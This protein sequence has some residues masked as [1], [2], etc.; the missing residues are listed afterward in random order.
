MKHSNQPAF[1]AYVPHSQ[2]CPHIIL[3][4]AGKLCGDRIPTWTTTGVVMSQ[5]HT[6][7]VMLHLASHF[8][9]VVCPFMSL[10]IHFLQLLSIS[11]I[12]VVY[13]IH[14]ESPIFK[15]ASNLQTL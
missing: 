3:E 13:K 11:E 1:R 10:S 6:Y 4:R 15:F 14:Y 2:C 9:R 8:N 12:N 5:S 7:N